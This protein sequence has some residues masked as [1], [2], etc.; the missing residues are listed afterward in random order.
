MPL[1]S[2]AQPAVEVLLNGGIDGS[3]DFCGDQFENRLQ[4]IVRRGTDGEL[5]SAVSRLE[6]G[7]LSQVRAAMRHPIG[8]PF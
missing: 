8:N 3:L 7:W 2:I 6:M 5:K 1:P 4:Q